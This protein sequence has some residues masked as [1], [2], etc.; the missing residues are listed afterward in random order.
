MKPF[1]YETAKDIIDK[2]RDNIQNCCFIF[3]N[4]RTNFFFR[5]YYS[6]IY[7]KSHKAPLMTEIRFFV[8]RFTFLEDID[9]LSLIF[10]IFEI[11]KEIDSKKNYDFDSFYKLG[12]II[13]SDFNEI[14]NWLIKPEEIYR[15]IHDIKEIETHFDWLSDEQKDVLRNFWINFSSEEKSEEK[16]MFLNLW[17]RLPTVYEKL[18][19]KLLKKKVAYTGLQFRYLSQM[20]EEGKINL[21]KY[22]RYFFIGFNALNKGETTLFKY[23]QK[24]GKALFYWN[25]DSYYHNDAKQESGDFLR[26]NFKDLNIGTYNF[27]NNFIKEKSVNLIGVPLNISQAKILPVVL[28]KYSKETLSEK[29]AILLG[30]E[31]LLFPV[32][33]SLPETIDKINVS[34]GYPFKSTPLYQLIQLYVNLHNGVSNKKS[35]SFYYKSIVN[36]LRHP[37]VNSYSADKALN[38]INEITEKNIIFVQSKYLLEKNDKLFNLLFSVIPSKDSSILLLSNILNILFLIFD[39]SKDSE[40]NQVLSLKNEY[41]HRVYIKVKRLKELIQEKEIEIGIKLCINILI[42]NLRSEQIPFE[43]DAVEGLQL[44]GI[45]ESRNLDFEN[46]IILGLNEGIMPAVSRSATFISQSMRFAFDM[47]LIKHQDAVYAYL[48]YSLIQRAK[49]VTLIYNSI[50]NDSNSGELSRF[51]LQ[52]MYETNFKINHFQVNSELHPVKVS[53]LNIIKTPEIFEKLSKFYV[54]NEKQYK[55]FSS[56]SI[57]TYLDCSLKFYFK[58]IIA[59]KEPDIVEEEYSPAVF[60]S[61]LHKIMELIYKDILIK[62]KSGL[63]E[64]DDFK[65][66]IK[67][68]ESYADESFREYYNKNDSYEMTGGQEIIKNILIKYIKSIL[69]IDEQYAPFEII[70]IEDKNKYVAKL[71][72]LVNGKNQTVSI[73]GIIDRI[74]KKKDVYRIIDYKTG[75]SRNKFNSLEDLFNKTSVNRPTHVMQTLLY[76]YIFIEREKSSA[77]KIKPGIYYVRDMHNKKYDASLLKKSGASFM[78]VNESLISEIMPEFIEKLQEVLQEIFSEE[79]SFYQT[80]NLNTCIYCS[81]KSICNR[82]N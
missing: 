71:N 10:E 76:S 58:Y 65:D 33:S 19:S 16:E 31:H 73:R 66:I 21:D 22:N 4:K 5:K 53:S 14:D 78:K 52:L 63:I 2:N 75:R 50:V 56:A 47:P 1:L 81:Y 3:P 23:V 28:N 27:Q 45:L 13:L 30:D 7:G 74:D 25:T 26:K 64:K 42:Q 54:N 60:G 61:V 12:E 15:N 32:L 72:I 62:K 6:E 55:S 57:N 9:K 70:S 20:M 24:E 8:R 40:G 36:L 41:I 49:D 18:K 82:Q 29:T 35:S 77:L 79:K 48:F 43:G 17:N 59:L 68:I 46:V 39:K 51:A 34:M 69:K 67:K 38:T 37:Y 44:M 11:F 80:Q